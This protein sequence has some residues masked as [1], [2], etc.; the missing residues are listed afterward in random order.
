[1]PTTTSGTTSYTQQKHASGG[2]IGNGLE[3]LYSAY[4]VYYIY[5][6][7]YIIR[8]SANAILYRLVSG[9]RETSSRT[10]DITYSWETVIL[11]LLPAGQFLMGMTTLQA[12]IHND[13]Q[14]PL[15]YNTFSLVHLT[16]YYMWTACNIY[17]GYIDFYFG[18]YH[19]ANLHHGRHQISINLALIYRC[20][21]IVYLFCSLI[22]ADRSS[23]SPGW[24]P[25]HQC[26]V[27][28]HPR[29]G[30][31]YVPWHREFRLSLSLSCKRRP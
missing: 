8:V 21:G 20:I 17:I 4:S 30:D 29:E 18:T 23:S 15:A 22:H 3:K 9:E 14:P 10:C 24:L 6:L 27:D 7:H 11:T 2:E 1:M 12:Y 5:I 25:L 13:R 31:Y 16:M 28:G 19:F 26:Q